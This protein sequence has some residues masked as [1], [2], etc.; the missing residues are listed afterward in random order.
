LGWIYIYEESNQLNFVAALKT[1]DIDILVPNINRPVEKIDLVQVLEK[2]GFE[3]RRSS[4]GLVKFDK[5]GQIDVE[6]LVR[7]IG[8]GKMEPYKVNS[9]GVMAQGLRNMEILTD[10]TIVVNIKGFNVTV[11]KPAAYILHKL[12]INEERKPEYKQEKDINAVKALV[13]VAKGTTLKND[14]NTIYNTLTTKQQK[15]IINTCKKWDIELSKNLQAGMVRW[16]FTF[17]IK[18]EISRSKEDTSLK[19]LKVNKW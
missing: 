12:V 10:H 19:E 17:K 1:Q 8:K 6:F 3:S 13:A 15:K 14:M 18:D 5:D 7:E 11:P 2:E 9:L 16:H 4:D